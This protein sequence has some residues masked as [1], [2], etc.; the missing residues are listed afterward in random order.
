MRDFFNKLSYARNDLEQNNFDSSKTSDA[1]VLISKVQEYRKT[2]PLWEERKGVFR[3]CQKMLERQRY[4]F[5]DTWLYSDNI[6]GEFSSFV[7]I[8]SRKENSIK[9]H[10]KSF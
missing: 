3:E 10:V 4:Q 1:V 5:S 7:E 6:E 9:K 8:L 2:I